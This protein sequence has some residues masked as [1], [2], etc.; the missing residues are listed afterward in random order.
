[1]TIPACIQIFVLLKL[2]AYVKTKHLTNMTMMVFGFHRDH[3]G[4]IGIDG[5]IFLKWT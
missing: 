2:I 4:S 5:R 1:V 3:V